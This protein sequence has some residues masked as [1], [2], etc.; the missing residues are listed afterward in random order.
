MLRVG[1]IAYLSC[2][3]A[4]GIILAEAALRPLRRPIDGAEIRLVA[5]DAKRLH[6]SLEDVQITSRDGIL[7]R[8][9]FMVPE[10]PNGSLVVLL[11]GVADNRLGVLDYAKLLVGHGYAALLPDARAHGQSGGTIATYGILEK[12]DIHAW[13]DWAERH[14]P[15]TCVYGFGESM[16]AA[17]ALQAIAEESRLCGLVAESPFATFREIAIDR[18]GQPFHAGPWLGRSLLRAV[19]E[20]GILYVRLRYGINLAEAAPQ[21]AVARSHTPVLLIHGAE[22]VNI[23]LRHSLLLQAANR[24]VG[25]WVVPN[26]FHTGAWS[27][28]P[29]E[30]PQRL[31]AALNSRQ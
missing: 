31:L 14:H 22:D 7:L 16:G 8:G 29:T 23:P 6:V 18:V 15:P 10:H 21:L 24:G 1:V 26:A 19:V 12:R 27:A 28:S 17:I 25:L 3:L 13:I 30:F 4:L 2:S 11:H 20:S 9:W 5:S